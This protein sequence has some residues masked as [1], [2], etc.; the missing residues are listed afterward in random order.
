M[1]FL[2]LISL[3]YKE[4]MIKQIYNFLKINVNFWESFKNII[5]TRTENNWKE[6]SLN[7]HKVVYPLELLNI[8]LKYKKKELLLERSIRSS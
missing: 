8:V 6:Y 5:L 4:D 7:F 2:R 3:S 1:F